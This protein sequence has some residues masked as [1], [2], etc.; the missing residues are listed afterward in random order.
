VIYPSLGLPASKPR[1]AQ[2][3]EV[4]APQALRV[5]PTPSTGVDVLCP[6]MG[7]LFG[8]EAYHIDPCFNQGVSVTLAPVETIINR[9]FEKVVFKCKWAIHP[10]LREARFFAPLTPFFII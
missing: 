4:S 1:L 10:R 5:A 3:V 6:L 8:A 7:M 2:R 9:V